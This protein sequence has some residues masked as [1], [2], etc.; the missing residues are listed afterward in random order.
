LTRDNPNAPI[1]RLDDRVRVTVVKEY[2]QPA[3]GTTRSRLAKLVVG[4]IVI[5][6]GFDQFLDSSLISRVIRRD[7]FWRE[8][9]RE[10]MNGLGDAPLDAVDRSA[11]RFAE[12]DAAPG[13]RIALNES[14]VE[15]NPDIYLFAGLGFEE[16]GFPDATYGRLRVGAQSS[17]VRAWGE[18]PAP[19]G[20]AD[21]PFFAR[22]LGASFG[23]G[24]S[25]SSERFYGAVSFSDPSR[26]TT[27]ANRAED[28]EFFLTKAAL[29][30][31]IIP[32]GRVSMFDVVAR[33]F[34]GATYIDVQR[35]GPFGDRDSSLQPFA[36]R[37]RPMLRLEL[38]GLDAD[39]SAR[40]RI[41]LELSGTSLSL[42]WSEQFTPLF[43][44][45]VS[46]QA[47]ALFGDRPLYLPSYSIALSPVFTLR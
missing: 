4:T 3:I 27:N 8:E 25:F 29:A 30:S 45:R 42:A 39:A 20:S 26:S 44:L 24:L 34:V 16:L 33:A 6:N 7:Y 19:I 28:S 10:A 41:A 15:I 17:G 36:Q 31:F 11:Y 12:V 18:I 46:A 43:G 14:F 2:A 23:G 21:M 40:R 22:A 1:A 47:N 32:F 37:V 5:D 38:L 35:N 9:T 13:T